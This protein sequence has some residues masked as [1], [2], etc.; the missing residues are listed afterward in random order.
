MR[1]TEVLFLLITRAWIAILAADMMVPA[2]PAIARALNI[3]PRIVQFSLS[4]SL[5]AF[6]IGLLIFGALVDR[7]G[8]RSIL[9][10]GSGLL[11]VGGLIAGLAETAIAFACG[12]LLLDLGSSASLVAARVMLRDLFDGT[13]FV[14]TQAHVNAATTFAPLMTPL[15]G[16]YLLAFF[17]WRAV[18][19]A[20]LPVSLMLLIIL[21]TRL[22]E[23]LK[24]SERSRLSL[25]RT[26]RSQFSLIS[27]R[28]FAVPVSALCA[29][30]AAVGASSA[31]M[32]FLF[33]DKLHF[34]PLAFA[35]LISGIFLSS[36]AGS[37]AVGVLIKH[38]SERRLLQIG[39]FLLLLGGV[40]I[41]GAGVN[42]DASWLILALSFILLAVAHAM[43]TPLCV[44]HAMEV[45]PPR[46]GST[47]AMLGACQTGAWALA[48]MVTSF[49]YTGAILPVA[50]VV[51]TCAVIAVFLLRRMLA[52]CSLSMFYPRPPIV[53]KSKT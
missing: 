26:V 19:L 21:A 53:D 16:G 30:Q 31:A 41:M 29:S 9:L 22:P 46:R 28:S 44:T 24:R 8:R 2:L 4:L 5:V 14:K 51:V 12:L 3:S 6:A 7:Y 27:Q 15:L 18:F 32:P 48:A 50:L 25:T 38:I 52:S 35:Y 1:H 11:I 49:V 40:A 43:I 39:M 10:G 34:S 42:R 37:Y 13:A 17:G 36:M 45:P 33:I 20:I 23:T 47:A